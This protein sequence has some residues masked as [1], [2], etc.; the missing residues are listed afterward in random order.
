M[1]SDWEEK[2]VKRYNCSE[3]VFFKTELYTFLVRLSMKIT[4]HLILD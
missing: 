4:S 2:C 3:D 1:S